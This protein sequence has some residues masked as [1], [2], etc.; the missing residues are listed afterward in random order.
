MFDVR[1]ELF[2]AKHTN[3][4]CTMYD[5]RCDLSE[6]VKDF[7]N[8]ICCDDQSPTLHFQLPN[9]TLFYALIFSTLNFMTPAGTCTSATSPITLPIRPFPMGE[10]IDILFNLRS[11]SFS[12]TI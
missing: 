10:V 3:V 9:R 6:A 4:R 1:C 8:T 12:E 5:V 2:E 11:A 7:W